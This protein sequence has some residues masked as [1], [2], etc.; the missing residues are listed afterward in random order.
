MLDFIYPPICLACGEGASTRFLCRECWT[1]CSLPDPFG[2]CRGCFEEIDPKY[3]LCKTCRFHP[4]PS[5]RA[6]VFDPESPACYL[7]LDA[8][9]AMASFAY[10][11]WLQLEWPLPTVLIAMPDRDSIAVGK[12]LAH[13]LAVPFVRAFSWE[14]I[15][16]KDRLEEGET[17]LI[18]DVA[19]DA[20]SI[21]EAL[22]S[23]QEAFPKKI[24]QLSL[25]PYVDCFS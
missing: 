6:Y 5:I 18:F 10:I 17:L 9:D 11:Q 4:S 21:Q 22:I 8:P 12:E 24:Y 19:S 13:L 3:D 25:L 2:R 1:L 23:I 16:K 7:G 15:Y 14:G 20:E